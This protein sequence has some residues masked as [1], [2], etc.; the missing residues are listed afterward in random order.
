MGKLKDRVVEVR[1]RG[2]LSPFAASYKAKLKKS[3]STWQSVV[4]KLRLLAHFSRW[5][6]GRSV[7]LE[8]LDRQRV[9]EFMAVRRMGLGA[10]ASVSLSLALLLAPSGRPAS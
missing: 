5:L 2:P 8:D 1:F 9:A 3:G 7:G 10:R 6:E 4:D